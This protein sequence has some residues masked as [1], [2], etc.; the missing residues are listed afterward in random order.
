MSYWC[1]RLYCK[2][3]SQ[4][5]S[6]RF[7]QND[8]LD[9]LILFLSFRRKWED[10]NKIAFRRTM[11]HCMIYVLRSN[12]ETEYFFKV[13][14]KIIDNNYNERR[15]YLL[16]FW[17]SGLPISYYLFTYANVL[18]GQNLTRYI[19]PLFVKPFTTLLCQNFLTRLS[20]MNILEIC[21]PQVFL[22]LKVI[23]TWT[24]KVKTF[25]HN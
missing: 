15:V 22:F 2:C 1:M 8:S 3:S 13:A 4:F 25:E 5:T 6:K 20:S 18:L 21:L 7:F 23:G 19:L 9:K 17:F 10:K 24:Q 16:I 12:S 14:K 11:P